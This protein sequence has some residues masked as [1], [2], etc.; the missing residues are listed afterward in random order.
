MSNS[1]LIL[2]PYKCC[3]SETIVSWIQ[4]ERTFRLWSSDRFDSFPLSA[5]A[6]AHKYNELNGDCSEPDNF[7]PLT[8][9]EG[10]HPIGS[11]IL[12]YT[13]GNH[14]TLRLGFVILDNTLRGHGYGKTMVKLAL[15]YVF[16][17][18]GADRATIG[19]F[20][21]NPSAYHCYLS[22]GFREIPMAPSDLEAFQ[23]NEE[24]WHVIELELTR[25]EYADLL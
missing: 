20:D 14:H 1:N 7:Y 9:C 4:D 15:K 5:E 21:S 24:T 19:V 18:L 17:I 2:R 12:R 13:G 3:D 8:L 22:A 6:L 25:E 10:E 23:W 16:E 11:L